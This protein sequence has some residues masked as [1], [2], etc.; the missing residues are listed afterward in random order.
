MPKELKQR[1]SHFKEINWSEV[2]R[3][4]IWEKTRILEKMK[5]LLSKSSLGTLEIERN[6]VQIRKRV[7]KKHH[8]ED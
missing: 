4:A 1:M 7:F 3:V 8:K 5:E 2:A 6:S